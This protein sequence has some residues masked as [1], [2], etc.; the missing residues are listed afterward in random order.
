MRWPT[1]GTRLALRRVVQ[2][3]DAAA[4]DDE[5]IHDVY[6]TVA[7]VRDVEHVSR[8]L[9]R[10]G[11]E[12]GEEGVGAAITLRHHSPVEVGARVVLEATVTHAEGRRMVTTVEVRCG[13]VVAAEGEFT[14]VV[15]RTEGG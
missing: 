14:Q 3:A 2:P 12:E 15:L 10:L 9:F 11:L 7:M 5:H 4:F 6:S 13:D 8:Q 1:V